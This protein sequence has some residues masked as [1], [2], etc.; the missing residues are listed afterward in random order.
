MRKIIQLLRKAGA[1]E[2]HV[3]IGCPPVVAPCYYGVDMRTRDQFIATNR[4]IDEIADYLTADSVKYTTIKD[5]EE[6]IGIPANKLC[7][8]CLN[9]EYPTAISGEKCRKQQT[10]DV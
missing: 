1:K 10:L 2:V 6:A 7:V 8:A 5:V 3:R 4:T 9:G